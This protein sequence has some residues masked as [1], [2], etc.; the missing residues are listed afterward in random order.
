MD[1]GPIGPITAPPA[2]KRKRVRRDASDDDGGGPLDLSQPAA[3]VAKQILRSLDGLDDSSKEAKTLKAAFSMVQRELGAR[4]AE[5]GRATE[6]AGSRAPLVFSG[7]SVPEVCFQHIV[8]FVSPWGNYASL[9]AS[10]KAALGMLSA[11][12]RLW[13]RALT[14]APNAELHHGSRISMKAL[15]AQLKK[16]RYADVDVLCL[17]RSIKVGETGLASL[18]KVLPHLTAL[19]FGLSAGNLHPKD[20]DLLAAARDLPRLRS[21]RIDMWNATPFGVQGFARAMGAR[22]LDLRMADDGITHNYVTDSVLS[23]IAGS[24]PALTRLSLVGAAGG[25]SYYRQGQ[26]HCTTA[27]ITMLLDGVGSTLARLDIFKK[28]NVDRAE[29][30]TAIAERLERGALPRL[31]K[32]VW[33][34]HESAGNVV[35][36]WHV[37]CAE[38][39][40][41]TGLI[42]PAL[43]RIKARIEAADGVDFATTLGGE[44]FGF[45]NYSFFAQE[46]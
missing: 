22:L 21:L 41:M 23:V 46:D 3:D 6:R 25:G 31:K 40:P 39:E 38:D 7:V 28:G 43:V 15:L 1:H 45:R 34:H 10:H 8:E 16:P 36:P 11:T 17:P 27:G 20:A 33:V 12:P 13:K 9:L 5:R 2:G 30:G 26:D 29:T 19:D 44:R 35:H 14:A 4:A 32:L 24:C 42:D 37:R 18:G